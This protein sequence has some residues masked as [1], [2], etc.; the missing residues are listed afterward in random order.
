MTTKQK[1]I[2]LQEIRSLAVNQKMG[3][4]LRLTDFSRSDEFCDL[5][6]DLID[7]Y[8]DSG[9]FRKPGRY[10][11]ILDRI[12]KNYCVDPSPHLEG[13]VKACKNAK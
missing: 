3:P 10:Y 12:E 7:F 5:M 2:C 11:A 9:S 4:F 1:K 6:I 13:I 8:F